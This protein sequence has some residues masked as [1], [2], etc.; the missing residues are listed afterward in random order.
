MAEH[1]LREI[2]K[3]MIDSYKRQ[4]EVESQDRFRTEGTQHVKE[5]E[6]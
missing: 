5:K 6:S 2:T 4:V 3:T 1:D